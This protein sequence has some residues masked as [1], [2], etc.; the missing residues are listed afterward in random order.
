MAD[1]A[2]TVAAGA[3][4]NQPRR[5]DET[6]LCF[7]VAGVAFA[8]YLLT[9]SHNFTDGE[10]ALRYARDI[11]KAENLFLFG[12]HLIFN[13]VCVGWFQLWT[14]LG[15]AGNALVPTQ[16]LSASAAAVSLGLIVAL[17]GRFGL[18]RPLTIAA[19]VGTG[20]SSSFW[21]YAGLSDTYL[22]PVPFALAGFLCLW[23]AVHERASVR[24]VVAAAVSWSISTLLHQQNV[25][26]FGPGALMLIFGTADRRAG[27]KWAVLLLGLGCALTLGTY[28][29]AAVFG[30]G[31]HSVPEFVKWTLGYANK[32]PWTP[33]SVMS[34]PKG[35]VGLLR[36]VF[37]INLTMGLDLVEGFAKRAAPGMLLVEERYF[38]QHL[39]A[40]ART[41]ALAAMIASGVIA[42]GVLGRL[43]KRAAAVRKRDDTTRDPHRVALWLGL[44]LLVQS[45]AVIAWEPINPEFWIAVLP[46]LWLLAAVWVHRS[47]DR[48]SRVL[49][50]AFIFL[51]G[52]S[53]A[54]GYIVPQTDPKSDYW[55]QANAVPLA[56]LEPGDQ[57]VTQGAYVSNG[58]LSLQTGVLVIEGIL[59]TEKVH[60]SILAT[61]ATRRILISSWVLDPPA[62]LIGN[63]QLKGWDRAGMVKLMNCYG[64]NLKILGQSSEQTVWE[65]HRP[66]PACELS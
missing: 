23:R 19:A 64:P 38:A 44:M 58:Y 24:W 2:A 11:T 40:L 51:L 9:L 62:F 25:L 52:S 1:R 57:M 33:W 30:L 47:E 66:V 46:W 31:L 65:L 54:I 13:I 49:W 63:D 21:A 37:A 8:I 14:A 45:I 39:S 6:T 20:V 4:G 26:Y 42:M 61:P 43:V 15:Y 17:G 41:A 22:L 3:L 60:R 32:G 27:L 36:S 35:V 28:I 59:G 5:R 16:V 7:A 56:L 18:P 53:N 10:D 50:F 55:R 29:L 48:L 34:I 12:N